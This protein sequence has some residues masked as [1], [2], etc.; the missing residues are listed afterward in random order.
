MVI[1]DI[2]RVAVW[3]TK[4]AA[5]NERDGEQ[6]SLQQSGEKDKTPQ[7]V[8]TLDTVKD[9]LEAEVAGYHFELE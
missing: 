7:P 1:P 3:G 6:F 5:M 4:A 2:A 9:E 8:E